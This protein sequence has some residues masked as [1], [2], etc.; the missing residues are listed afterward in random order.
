[1]TQEDHIEIIKTALHIFEV[2][3]GKSP[4][5]RLESFKRDPEKLCWEVGFSRVI[6]RSIMGADEKRVQYLV[7]VDYSYSDE[8]HRVTS[9]GKVEQCE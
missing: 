9:V 8:K 4:D 3:E 6:G 2:A 5:L 1:M 7:T